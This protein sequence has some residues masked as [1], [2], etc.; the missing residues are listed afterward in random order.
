MKSTPRVYLACLASYNAGILHGRWIELDG[1]E[2]LE[3]GLLEMRSSSP[4]ND[5]DEWA[6]HDHEHCG[7]L[8]EYPGLQRL[9]MLEEAFKHA[10]AEGLDWELLCAFCDHAGH[11]LEP[12]SVTLFH[13]SFTGSGFSLVDWCRQFFEETGEIERIPEHLRHYI[14]Y[15][16]YARDLEINDVFTVEHG[17]ETHVFWNN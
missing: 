13:D 16:A 4:A 12:Q 8:G 2:D 15:Q 6:V 7:H 11:E 5:A 1:T 10:E 3:E 17:G 9:K 14:D